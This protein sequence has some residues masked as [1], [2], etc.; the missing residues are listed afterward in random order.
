RLLVFS[1]SRLLVF[2][3]SRMHPLLDLTF[4]P[5]VGHRGNA[6]HAPE[7]TLESFRQAVALGVDALEFDVRLTR[8]GEVVVFHDATVKR[9]TGGAGVV[10]AMT[11]DAMRRLDAGAT[12]TTNRGSV[13]P[14]RGRGIGV[15]TLA[16][17]LAA[18]PEMPMLIEV[19]V[20]EAARPARDVI[21]RAGAELRCIAASFHPEALLPFEESGIAV[22]SPPAS[23]VPMCIPALLGRRYT[24]LTFQAMSLPRV[25]R[26]IPVPLGALARATEPAGVPLHVWTINDPAIALRL[27]RVGVRGILS[28]DPAAIMRAHAEWR[29]RPINRRPS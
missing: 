7:N 23:I 28:D 17:V 8:D 21:A 18:F 5:V 15:S 2:S 19:K 13:F 1:S 20:V 3:S 12:F 11:L 16:E 22:S 9:T 29:A 25:Y 14:Y 27:W 10:A 26:G 6:A 4:R 24:S